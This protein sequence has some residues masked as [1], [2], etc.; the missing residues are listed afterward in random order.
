MMN[1]L[2]QKN[3]QQ[4]KDL[5]AQLQTGLQALLQQSMEQMFNRLAPA[6]TQPPAATSTTPP[7]HIL[8]I[9][10][11]SAI[12]PAKTEEPMDLAPS[13]PAPPEVKK[14]LSK[15]KGSSAIA[16]QS[17]QAVV[18]QV[19]VP[20]TT[21]STQPSSLP[22]AASAPRLASPLQALEQEEYRTDASASSFSS[23]S[24]PEDP[25]EVGEQVAP[26]NLPFRELVQKVRE[27]LSIPDPA[28][29]ED[30]KLGSALGRDPLLLQQEK[31]DRPPS[32][33]LP[34]VANL[35]RLQTA[36][37]DSVKPSTSNTLEMGKFPGIPPHKGSWCSVVDDKFAQA[38]Q[39]VPQ[40]FSNIAKPGYRSGPPAS[41]QQKDLVKLEYMTRENISIA[42]FLSTFGMASESCLNN[43]RLSRDQRER[44]F[45][46]FRATTDGPTREQI[47]LQL[48]TMTQQESA[49]M[50]FMLDIS[51]SMS[52]AYA[53]LVSNFL[54]TLTNLVLLGCDA[55]LRHAHP[56]LDAFRVRNLRAAPVSGGDLFERSLM[57]EY[58]QHMIGLGVKPGSKKEQRFHP[59]KK[60]KMG[61]GGR[62][63]APQGVYYQPMPAPQYMVQ[64]PFFQPPPQGGRRGHGGRR[65]RGCGG[66]TGGNKQHQ[67]PQ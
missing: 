41:V 60:N 28:A 32:I 21:P 20:T 18:S 13:Q 43:L 67:P 39:M 23:A 58:E 51:R 36:H 27:F 62:Q 37:D 52:K 53:D 1:S 48:F 16:Q 26:P 34:M 49:Q 61:R 35:S 3:Q 4:I 46:Q 40:A 7:P 47:M 65:G 6:Q 2:Q 9:T 29:E 57:Q 14:G 50:Q 5:S 19:K 33:K 66:S 45:D 30:Y 56:N 22:T 12:P 54:S 31:L 55:Y 17:I 63:Q 11:V 59:Y 42:N 15:V 8:S 25:M 64:K 44:L 24:K 38:P 10:P